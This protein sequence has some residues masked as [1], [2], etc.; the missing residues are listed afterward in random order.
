MTVYA[1]G[2]RST[3]LGAFQP[4]RTFSLKASLQPE[5]R[6]FAGNSRDISKAKTAIPFPGSNPLRSAN[7]QA[8]DIK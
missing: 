7:D 4:L 3:E 5:I 1:D 6:H 8:F 2:R